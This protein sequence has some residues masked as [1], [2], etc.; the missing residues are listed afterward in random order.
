MKGKA[1]YGFLVLILVVGMVMSPFP[2][3]ERAEAATSV[4]NVWVELSD[5]TALNT[6]STDLE[7]IIHF[8]AT[9]ALSGGADT[10]TVTF[11]DGTTAMA[12]DEGTDYAF[13]L[14]GPI[15]AADVAV[16]PDGA[17]TTTTGYT[18]CYTAPDVGTYRVRLTLPMDI[19][20]GAS[21]YIKFET[22]AAITSASTEGTTYRVKVETSQDT[23][24]V[25]TFTR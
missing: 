8:T 23:T 21:P 15:E 22:G 19:A 25:Y 6:T 16:D 11:P 14:T 13:T 9:T 10:I 5:S 4:T 1:V 7:Y 2:A 20:A 18:D 3:I 24:A 17:L 12:G